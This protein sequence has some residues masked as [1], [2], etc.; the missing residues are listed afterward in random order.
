MLGNRKDKIWNRG[1]NIV[2]HHVVLAAQKVISRFST[3]TLGIW[4]EIS[5]HQLIKRYDG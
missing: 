2:R 3:N 4:G 5:Q 1:H